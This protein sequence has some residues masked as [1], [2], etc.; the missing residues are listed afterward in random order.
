MRLV[1]VPTTRLTTHKQRRTDGRFGG[2][3]LPCGHCGHCGQW[4]YSSLHLVKSG[5]GSAKPP[6]WRVD[7]ELVGTLVGRIHWES[8]PKGKGVWEGWSSSGRNSWRCRS[9]LGKKTSVDEQGT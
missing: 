5:G 1:R 2:Q 3:E 8:V 4:G 7:F 9:R 6:P